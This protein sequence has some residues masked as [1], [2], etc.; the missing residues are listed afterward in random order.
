[1]LITIK[2]YL[3]DVNQSAFVDKESEPK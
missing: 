1:L 3:L 2:N